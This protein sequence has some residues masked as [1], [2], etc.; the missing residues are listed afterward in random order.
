M[1]NLAEIMKEHLLKSLAMSHLF[2]YRQSMSQWLT[3]YK[4]AKFIRLSVFCNNMENIQA[5]LACFSVEMSVHV[6]SHAIFIA[7]SLIDNQ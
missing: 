2:S 1:D 3:R 4:Q 7:C 5:E 6:T